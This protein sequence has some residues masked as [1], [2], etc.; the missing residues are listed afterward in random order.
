M[1]KIRELTAA[2]KMAEAIA[3]LPKAQSAIDKAAKTNAIHANAAAR[4]KARLAG[5]LKAAGNKDKTP[6][7]I[8]KTTESTAVSK[9]AAKKPV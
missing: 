8:S 3:E 4:Q 6:A 5:S 2:G 1:K 9:P 7:R